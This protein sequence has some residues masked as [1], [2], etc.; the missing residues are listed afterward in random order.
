M[1]VRT[2]SVKRPRQQSDH[3]G[4]PDFDQTLA[5]LQHSDHNQ[6]E[7]LMQVAQMEAATEEATA[8]TTQLGVHQVNMSVTNP[9]IGSQQPSFQT[10]AWLLRRVTVRNDEALFPRN[11]RKRARK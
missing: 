4:H 2:G 1:G 10:A 8:Q 6:T 5:A 9:M 7:L 11:A 3:S